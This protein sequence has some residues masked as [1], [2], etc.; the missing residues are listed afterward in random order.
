MFGVTAF[1]LRK[2]QLLS[3]PLAILL[4]DP[5]HSQGEDRFLVLGIA[6]LL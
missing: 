3:D 2:L 1:R 5:D 6:M 4:P